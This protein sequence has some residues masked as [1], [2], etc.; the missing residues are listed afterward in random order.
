MKGGRGVLFETQARERST[1]VTARLGSIKQCVTH[2]RRQKHGERMHSYKNTLAQSYRHRST[3]LSEYC[4]RERTTAVDQ[5]PFSP[6][7]NT[8]DNALDGFDVSGVQGPSLRVVGNRR[9]R[10]SIGK[11]GMNLLNNCETN[12][13]R[14]LRFKFVAFRNGDDNDVAKLPEKCS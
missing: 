11:V 3:L 2:Q 5:P 7:F 10:M 9:R 1:R 8:A 4:M 12:S 13:L 6:V 14:L